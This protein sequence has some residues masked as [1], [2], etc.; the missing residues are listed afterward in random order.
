M[1]DDAQQIIAE[2]LQRKKKT[3]KRLHLSHVVKVRGGV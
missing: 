3:N 1:F 2:N